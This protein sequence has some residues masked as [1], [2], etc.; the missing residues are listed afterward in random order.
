MLQ[1]YS[2]RTNMAVQVLIGA[3]KGTR[4]ADLFLQNQH[5]SAGANRCCEG[6]SHCSFTSED[7]I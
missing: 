5:G 4:V 1:I 3:V 7:P 2:C 6:D